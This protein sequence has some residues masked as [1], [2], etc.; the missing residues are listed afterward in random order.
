MGTELT[1]QGYLRENKIS[2][3]IKHKKSKTEMKDRYT[4]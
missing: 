4:V 1:Y 2:E 3:S